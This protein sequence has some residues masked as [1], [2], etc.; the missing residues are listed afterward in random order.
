[1]WDEPDIAREIESDRCW[2]VYLLAATD[3][4]AFKVGFSCNP[5]QRL[6][7]FNHR[8]FETF[9]LAASKV[10]RVVN[11]DLAREYEANIK[12][13]FSVYRTECPAW[14]RFDDAQAQLARQ[15]PNQA[16]LEDLEALVR[17][18]LVD[19]RSY[20][21]SWALAQGNKIVSARAPRERAL[22]AADAR[23]LRDWLDA[24]RH[25]GIPIFVDDPEALQVLDALASR[26]TIS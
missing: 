4:S 20:F 18:E 13:T 21:E 11:C 17:S 7:S 5:L 10:L 1:M 8:Y 15:S 23:T 2:F 14:V 9:D 22:A 12:S 25:F 19:V 6:Y 16:A 26:A 24:Y 3:C